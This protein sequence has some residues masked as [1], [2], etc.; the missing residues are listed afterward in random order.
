MIMGL[1]MPQIL[2]SLLRRI[3]SSGLC[4][5]ILSA[6][7]FHPIHQSSAQDSMPEI[8][9]NQINSVEGAE[10][11]DHLSS[12]LHNTHGARYVLDAKLHH[13]ASPL[14]ITKS[15][16]IVQQSLAQS[17]TYTLLDQLTGKTISGSFMVSGSFNATYSAYATDVEEKNK[18]MNLARQAA[19]EMNRRLIIYFINNR[20]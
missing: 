17:V 20:G 14:A 3:V 1:T 15:S 18:V 11:Y 6:C 13:T 5:L 2:S 10:F 4:L 16:D 12:L 7:G 9:I 8:Q 19:E